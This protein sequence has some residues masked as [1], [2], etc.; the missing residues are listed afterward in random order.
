MMVI[1]VST[2]L[3]GEQCGRKDVYVAKSIGEALDHH[4]PDPAPM[5]QFLVTVLSKEA[6]VV[7]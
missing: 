5:A 4:A 1:E 7:E 3:T 6:V 2:R